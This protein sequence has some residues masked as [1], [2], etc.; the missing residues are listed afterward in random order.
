LKLGWMRFWASISA[1]LILASSAMVAQTPAPAT[2]RAA[3]PR[4]VNEFTL[5]GLRPG[6]DRASRAIRKFKDPLPNKEADSVLRWEH[7]CD[8]EAL[9]LDVDRNG[10]VQAI[11]VARKVGTAQ[12]DCIRATRSHWAT[13]H[14]LAIHDPVTRVMTLYG[15]PDSRSPSTKDGQQLELLYYAFDWAGP[16]VP[17]VME[18][19]CTKEKD[20]KPG[21][22]IEITLA[23]ASL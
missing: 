17:Q 10:R 16:N 14:D 12:I 9:F 3:K 15:A 23:A 21:Q 1:L 11:R 5:A 18:V 7:P 4:R 13:G 19:L 6:F 22:V 2:Q 20:G 8:A